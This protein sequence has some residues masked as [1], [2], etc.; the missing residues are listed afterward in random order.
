MGNNK[1]GWRLCENEQANTEN[2]DTQMSGEGQFTSHPADSYLPSQDDAYQ[3]VI[4]CD[5]PA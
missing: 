3:C 4:G 1:N 5:D 2:N